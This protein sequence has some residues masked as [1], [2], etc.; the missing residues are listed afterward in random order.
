MNALML[1]IG[2]VCIAAPEHAMA[3]R[4]TKTCLSNAERDEDAPTNL[5]TCARGQVGWPVRWPAREIP[6]MI[7][8]KGFDGILP[9]VNGEINPE[10]LS[11]LR[12][13]M[14][15]WSDANC[16]DFKF[17]YMGLTDVAAHSPEDGVN[18][19]TFVDDRWAETSATIAL[20]ST[21]MT[22]QGVLVDADMEFNVRAH[23]FTVTTP[24]GSGAMDLANTT[25]H[26]AGHMLGLDE[27]AGKE[28]TMYYSAPTEESQ[29]RDLHPD[30]IAGICA[31]YP[32]GVPN[33]QYGTP[34]DPDM[35]D[36]DDGGG[37][38]GG[39]CSTV[40]SPTGDLGTRQRRALLA[41]GLLGLVGMWR[42]RRPEGA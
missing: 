32:E 36:D 18:V 20:T 38:G 9:A 25:T 8:R 11:T 37:G 31:I 21:T 12:Q 17:T 27:A 22:Q 10:V 14:R 26:E 7:N 4:Q 1:S 29:K 40:E 19:I 41:V 5:P 30:D 13:S 39:C 23:R 42:R 16:S 33:V 3:Y 24:V 28:A 15:Q 34:Y 35:S 2:L 6:Y